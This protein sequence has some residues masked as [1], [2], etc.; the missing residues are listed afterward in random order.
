MKR[1]TFCLA[2][3]AEVSTHIPRKWTSRVPKLVSA[4][5]EPAVDSHTRTAESRVLLDKRTG[6][7]TEAWLHNDQDEKH[8]I[9]IAP[10]EEAAAR[11]Q[12]GRE[13]DSSCIPGALVIDPLVRGVVGEKNMQVSENAI[14][15]LVVA[16]REHA[17]NLLR[18]AISH[19]KNYE[20]GSAT[21]PNLYCDQF[22]ANRKNPVKK[23]SSAEKGT[24]KGDASTHTEQTGHQRCLHTLD[25]FMGSTQIAGSS[26]GNIGGSVSR[27]A[28]ETCLHSAFAPLQL[29]PESEFNEVQNYFVGEIT[30]VARMRKVEVTLKVE[31]E[32]PSDFK[33]VEPANDP[34][35]LGQVERNLHADFEPTGPK[36]PSKGKADQLKE[37]KGLNPVETQKSQ[38]VQSSLPPVISERPVSIPVSVPVSARA[39]EP[40][41]TQQ[42]VSVPDIAPAAEETPVEDAQTSTTSEESYE[43]QQN[44]PRGL[45]RSAKNLA[46]LLKRT[47]TAQLDVEAEKPTD[48]KTTEVDGKGAANPKPGKVDSEIAMQSTNDE[49]ASGQVPQ[50]PTHVEEPEKATENEDEDDEPLRRGKGF[51]IKNLAA[52]RARATKET[53]GSTDGNNNSA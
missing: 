47:G 6:V 10:R 49:G 39:S 51:G 18:H 27:F 40:A 26:T 1:A 7:F 25:I 35:H 37:P 19:R 33:R 38:V 5:P 42:P 2:P 14:W 29:P 53:P 24:D 44:G 31:N 30:S 17:S 11:P 52:M 50:P 21:T 46:A 13:Y 4:E 20:D 15:L 22:L 28:L 48:E 16:V 36:R 43:G 23:D 34:R 8:G 3:F 41:P 45:G 9:A 12:G 32:L